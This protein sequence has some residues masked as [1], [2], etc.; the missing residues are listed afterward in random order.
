MGV[1]P[2]EELNKACEQF[3]R[4]HGELPV[5]FRVTEAAEAEAPLAEEADCG[6]GQGCPAPTAT[7]VL[8][9]TAE[10]TE[11]DAA[12]EPEAPLA[13]EAPESKGIDPVA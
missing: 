11:A 3:L 12:P 5:D 8:E 2:E 9:P 13:E 10:G 7:E 1:M 4:D 6:C